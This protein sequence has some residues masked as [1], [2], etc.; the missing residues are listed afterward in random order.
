M[1]E[2]ESAT[3]DA[4]SLPDLKD[5]VSRAELM[6]ALEQIFSFEDLSVKDKAARKVMQVLS[7]AGAAVVTQDVDTKIKRSSGISYREMTF[8][9]ADSQTVALRIKQTGDIYQVLLNKKLLPIRH[10]DDQ[11]KAIIEVINALDK[12]RAKYQQL[13]IKASTKLPKSIKTAAP[14][15]LIKLTQKRDDLNAAIAAVQEEIDAVKSSQLSQTDNNDHEDDYSNPLP[16]KITRIGMARLEVIDKSNLT[17]KIKELYEAAN[18]AQI[19]IEAKKDATQ[20][21][22]DSA[23][24]IIDAYNNEMMKYPNGTQGRGLSHIKHKK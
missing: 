20:E 13:L 7:R 3:A 1:R 2:L 18:K 8:G 19:N 4:L 6:K 11:N 21:E 23:N 15:M 22:I 9:F 12:N 16:M 14:T 17:G 5:G 10:Q 24:K